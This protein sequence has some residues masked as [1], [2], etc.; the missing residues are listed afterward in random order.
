[1]EIGGSNPP[2][3]ATPITTEC[4]LDLSRHYYSVCSRKYFQKSITTFIIRAISLEEIEMSARETYALTVRCK[5]CT[6]QVTQEVK[7]EP[8]ELVKVK[9]ELVKQAA[10][11]HK[12][13][14]DVQNF[15]VF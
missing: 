6:F 5:L 9:T 3:V 13:H 15:I 11:I 12:K 4:T 14:S 2:G 7:I 1:V 10:S 8:E